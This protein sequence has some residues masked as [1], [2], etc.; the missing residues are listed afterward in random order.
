MGDVHDHIYKRI[1]AIQIEI[2]RQTARARETAQAR[3]RASYKGGVFR[4]KRQ[5]IVLVLARKNIREIG[6]KGKKKYKT[7]IFTDSIYIQ[8]NFMRNKDV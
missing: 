2:E 8:S 4:D 1:H 3:A 7:N 6:S 5:G